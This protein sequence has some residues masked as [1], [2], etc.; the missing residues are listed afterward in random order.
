MIIDM[1]GRKMF[2]LVSKSRYFIL[3]FIFIIGLGSS[4]AMSFGSAPSYTITCS[5]VSQT[6]GAA[7]VTWDRDTLGTN[8]EN[9]HYEVTDGAGTIL[10]VFNDI[11]AVGSSASMGGWGFVV[12]PNYNPITVTLSSPGGNGF[13]TQV[14]VNVTGTCTGL[15][16]FAAPSSPVAPVVASRFEFSDGRINRFDTGNPVVL[17][18]M[19][20]GNEQT[21]LAV[22]S[23]D[24][25]LLFSVSPEEIASIEECPSVNTV[26]AASNGIIFS[27]LTINNDGICPFQINAPTADEGKF[28]IVI[29]DALS[30]S[31]NY[32]SF[33]E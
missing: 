23:P 13:A 9:L 18:P 16:T 1:K 29:F 10:F 25:D 8:E 12:A 11:R 24:G 20:Y 30:S 7:S 17:Y 27:R 22:Y 4:Q 21:G 28:Y 33:E 6:N 5:G 14:L 31:S 19:D 26:I 15:P 2:S 3:L 32:V